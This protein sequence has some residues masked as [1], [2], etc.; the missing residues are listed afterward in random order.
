[1]ATT[2]PRKPRRLAANTDDAEP[3]K[4]WWHWF[5]VYPA[6]GLALISA[7]PQWIDK[8]GAAIKGLGWGGSLAAAEKRNALW[9]K[10]ISCLAAPGAWSKYG[11]GVEIDATICNSGDIFVQAKESGTLI[12]KIHWVALEDVLK[13]KALG[14]GGGTAI[15]PS[16][17]AATIV[18][19][20]PGAAPVAKNGL[21]HQAQY[22]VLCQKFIDD[23]YIRRRV[24][25]PEG[26]FDEIIDSFTNAVVKRSP[27]PCEPVC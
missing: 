17:H 19:M 18:T 2:A 13:E 11:N 22:T 14:G 27:A 16:A 7:A 25:T 9:Q 3:K 8:T 1:M 23:R 20:M 10:N 5:L 21:F 24:S 12:P 26:C 15:I 4:P 6:L